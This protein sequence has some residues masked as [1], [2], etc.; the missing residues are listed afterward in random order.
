M[1]DW[2][3][4]LSPEE[5]AEWDAFVQ[6]ASTKTLEKMSESQ[7][8]ISLVPQ[9]KPDIKFC[10]ELGMAIMLGKPVLV[11]AVQGAVIPPKLREIADE[12]VELPGDFDTEE[13][14]AAVVAAIA[15]LRLDRE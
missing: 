5:R 12:T 15:R 13:G 7:F 10:A 6:R 3:E 9:G 14:R 1:N 8:M 11:M 4:Q 2:L